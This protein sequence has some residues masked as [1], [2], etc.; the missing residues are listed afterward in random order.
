MFEKSNFFVSKKKTQK[1]NIKYFTQK[2]RNM[3][4]N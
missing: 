4:N 1:E 3:I 2:H